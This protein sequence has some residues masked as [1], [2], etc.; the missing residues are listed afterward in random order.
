MYSSLLLG[1]STET[2]LTIF[3]TVAIFE[4]YHKDIKQNSSNSFKQQGPLIRGLLSKSPL[5][6]RSVERIRRNPLSNVRADAKAL[7][8]LCACIIFG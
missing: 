4:N 1:C 2:V 6:R 3:R 7:P 5:R 8:F